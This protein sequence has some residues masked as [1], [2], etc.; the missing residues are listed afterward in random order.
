MS[1]YEEKQKQRKLFSDPK[2]RI[3]IEIVRK[4]SKFQ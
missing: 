4:T 3:E 1:S 2:L